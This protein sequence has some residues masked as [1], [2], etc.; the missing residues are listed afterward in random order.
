VT[1]D[2]N[3]IDI[4]VDNRLRNVGQGTDDGNSPS[5]PHVLELQ[6]Y[7]GTINMEAVVGH[8]RQIPNDVVNSRWRANNK[9]SQ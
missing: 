5:H 1:G 7:A 2:D 3:H 9:R 6:W 8:Y 4:T